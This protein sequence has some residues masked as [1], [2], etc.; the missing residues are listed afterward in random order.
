MIDEKIG[1]VNSIRR[2]HLVFYIS[3]LEPAPKNAEIAT[4][5]EIEEETENEYEVDKILEMKRISG[6]PHYLVR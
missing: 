1:Q 6:K 3:L 4:N 2:I 5:V